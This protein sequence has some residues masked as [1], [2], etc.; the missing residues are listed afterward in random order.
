MEGSKEGEDCNLQLLLRLAHA[1]HLGVCIDDAGDG[2]VVHVP[3]LARKVFHTGNA[4]FLSLQRGEE[5]ERGDTD[6]KQNKTST[7]QGGGG[8]RGQGKG[9]CVRNGV[10]G[11]RVCV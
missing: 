3:G 5:G 1:S 9:G 6:Q 4:F 8:G 7:Q 10:G 2:V 11:K